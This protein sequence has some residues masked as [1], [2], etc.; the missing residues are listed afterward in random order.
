MSSP[1]DFIKHARSLRGAKWR[2]MGR[3]PWAIDCA[4]LVVVSARAAGLSVTDEGVYGREPWDDALR[5]HCRAAFGDPMP[6]ADAQPGDIAIMRWGDTEP[7]HVGIVG[8]YPNGLSLIHSHNL[9]GVVEQRIDEQ[10]AKRIIEIYRPRWE[11]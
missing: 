6:F 4:G 8:D 3:K 2:H 1:A 11:L 9:S 7:S 10:L 5:K